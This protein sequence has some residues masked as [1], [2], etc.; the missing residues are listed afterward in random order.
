MKEK[1]INLRMWLGLEKP[2]R[3]GFRGKEVETGSVYLHLGQFKFAT[4]MGERGTYY[5]TSI[6]FPVLLYKL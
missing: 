3:I 4:N 5:M 2:S 6:N 1:A